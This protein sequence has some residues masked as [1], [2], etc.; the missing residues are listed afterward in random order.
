MP[1]FCLIH[2]REKY[3]ED[4]RKNHYTTKIFSKLLASIAKVL[5]TSRKRGAEKVKKYL[6]QM[7]EK[8]NNIN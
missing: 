6:R 8:K 4:E 7:L 5:Y 3:S 1:F 2:D